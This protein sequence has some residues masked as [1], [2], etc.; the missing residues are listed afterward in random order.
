MVVT[1]DEPELISPPWNPPDI[2]HTKLWVGELKVVGRTSKLTVMS[3]LF[4]PD[5][6]SSIDNLKRAVQQNE[7]QDA[8]ITPVCSWLWVQYIGLSA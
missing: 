8:L 2:Q 6:Y 5:S 7:A 3:Y 1:G 4:I